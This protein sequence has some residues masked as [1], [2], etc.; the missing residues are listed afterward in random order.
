MTEEQLQELLDT[1][2]VAF[3]FE[4]P[5]GTRLVFEQLRNLLDRHWR[6]KGEYSPKTDWQFAYEIWLED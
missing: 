3:R 2:H 6:F 4:D 1:G 5:D